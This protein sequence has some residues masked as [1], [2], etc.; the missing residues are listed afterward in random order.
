MSFEGEILNERKEKSKMEEM[1]AH[2]TK[3][4][5]IFLS[6]LSFLKNKI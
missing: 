5:F 2:S 4:H 1:I 3:Q 6:K